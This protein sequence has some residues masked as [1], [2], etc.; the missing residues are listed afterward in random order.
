MDEAG[1]L[2]SYFAKN[3]AYRTGGISAN[4]HDEALL[5]C[6]YFNDHDHLELK[7][8]LGDAYWEIR[9]IWEDDSTYA[10]DYA[11]KL[12]EGYELVLVS[13]HGTSQSH[14]FSYQGNPSPFTVINFLV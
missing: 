1:L 11:Q 9:D 12:S 13:A 14:E 6:E 3:H 5:Y 8:Q 2:N 7:D 10:E 4:L